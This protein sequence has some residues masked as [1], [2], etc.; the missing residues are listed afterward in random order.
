M[1]ESLSGETSISS[2]QCLV[3]A[4]MYCLVK[5][6][7]QSLSRYRGL[8]IGMAQ[9]LGLYQSQTRFALDPLAT[10]T[11]KKVFW[12]QFILDR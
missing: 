3:L 4:Q 5:G 12:C 6:D 1:V 7:Y 9:V 2:M 11:R 10:E 8:A